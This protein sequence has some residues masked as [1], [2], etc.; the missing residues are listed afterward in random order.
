M[1]QSV[2]RARVGIGYRG[3]VVP[4]PT[5]DAVAGSGLLSQ[6]SLEATYAVVAGD[7]AALALGVAWD[8]GL[9][10]GSFDGLDLTLQVHRLTVPVEARYLLTP[11]LYGFGRVSPGAVFYYATIT[12]RGAPLEGGPWGFA[13]DVSGGV[14]VLLFPHGSVD[15]RVARVW[16]TPEGGY[17]WAA[18]REID[19]K[20]RGA[21]A[22]VA[23]APETLGALNVR[24]AFF[25][26]QIGLTF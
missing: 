3:S 25:R 13:M 2:G 22:V 7:R 16:L 12:D 4:D 20:G 9:R 21:P 11:W 26:V 14:S 5:F 8:F 1:R 10:D 6:L 24:G 15:R 19:L 23:G 18:E 17:G